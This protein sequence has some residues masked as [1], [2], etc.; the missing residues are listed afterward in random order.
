MEGA[1]DLE[2]SDGLVDLTGKENVQGRR[3]LDFEEIT[4]NGDRRLVK[5]RRNIS[6]KRLLMACIC[7]ENYSEHVRYFIS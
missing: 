7:S 3:S 1:S 2:L 4:L 6:V 5:E